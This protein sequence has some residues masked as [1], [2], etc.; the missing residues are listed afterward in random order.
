MA[1]RPTWKGF[2]KISL[3]NIPVKMY[4]AVKDHTISFHRLSEDGSCRLRTKLY[5][6]DTG[7]EYDFT[8]TARGYEV[9][10]DQYVIVE[11]EDVPGMGIVFQPSQD[12][13][14]DLT[15]AVDDLEKAFLSDKLAEEYLE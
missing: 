12:S 9:A 1:A 7:E 8:Q 10:P 15:K 3:V 14:A 2:L 5:C 11:D 6:P 13:L 4:K